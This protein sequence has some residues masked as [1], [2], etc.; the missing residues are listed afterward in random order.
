MAN[1]YYGLSR[2]ENTVSVDTSTT[3]KNVEVVVLEGAINGGSALR[4]A[5]ILEA[6]DKIKAAVMEDK[7]RSQI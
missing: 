5:E 6:L 7:T 4:K 2:G 1:I 3:S